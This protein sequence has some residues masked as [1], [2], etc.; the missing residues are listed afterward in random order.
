MSRALRF[1]RPPGP[2]SGPGPVYQNI[3]GSE[4]VSSFRV[5]GRKTLKRFR[6]FRLISLIDVSVENDF[7]DVNEMKSIKLCF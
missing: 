4:A 3:L 5:I 7:D 2:G 6:N 1:G